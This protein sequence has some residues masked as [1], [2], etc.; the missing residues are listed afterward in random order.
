MDVRQSI[1]LLVDRVAEGMAIDEAAQGL[2]LQPDA[3]GN[4][5]AD[6]LCL[7]GLWSRLDEVRL[8]AL[9]D[10]LLDHGADGARLLE[11]TLSDNMYADAGENPIRRHLL[12]RSPPKPTRVAHSGSGSKSWL[13]LWTSRHAFSLCS[14]IANIF[15]RG[16]EVTANGTARGGR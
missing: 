9:V 14:T 10:W 4:H 1:H 2:E 11:W 13:T 16:L 6:S 7:P 15:F 3:Q 5:A 8:F 12:A